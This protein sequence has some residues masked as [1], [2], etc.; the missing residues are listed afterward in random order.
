MEKREDRRD[1][2]WR[3]AF[4]RQKVHFKVIHPDGVLDCP[5][6]RSVWMFD[7]CRAFGCD[8]R[9]RRSGRP[10]IAGGLCRVG[11]RDHVYAGRRAWREQAQR[12]LQGSLCARD[13][14]KALLNQG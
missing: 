2:T 13:A 7:R 3:K 11:A 14:R 10:R 5:C 1:R 8:C 6:E 4:G 12:I 9:R